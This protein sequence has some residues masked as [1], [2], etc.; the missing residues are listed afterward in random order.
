MRIIRVKTG[1]E[2]QLDHPRFH[3]DIYAFWKVDRNSILDTKHRSMSTLLKRSRFCSQMAMRLKSA[4]FTN[5]T[6]RC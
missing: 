3:F 4:P 2:H 5:E 1:L 6:A